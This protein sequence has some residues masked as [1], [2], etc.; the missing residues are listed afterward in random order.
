MLLEDLRLLDFLNFLVGDF[1]TCLEGE[2]EAMETLPDN[3]RGFGWCGEEEVLP[4]ED[5]SE[6]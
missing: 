2:D 1:S 5:E 4:G 6:G 3:L